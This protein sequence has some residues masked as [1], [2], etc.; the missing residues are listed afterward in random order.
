MF[1]SILLAVDGSEYARHAAEA[2]GDLARQNNARLRVISV[3]DPCPGLMEKLY[4]DPYLA[5]RKQVAQQVIDEA[6]QLVGPG[7]E[8][9]TEVLVGMTADKIIQNAVDR[10]CDLIVMGTRGLSP[11]QGLLM[12]SQTQKVVSLAPCSVLVAR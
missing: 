2:A 6:L 10:G 1:K 7:V 4:L 8:A 12:G 11:L 9:D 3:V 5:E